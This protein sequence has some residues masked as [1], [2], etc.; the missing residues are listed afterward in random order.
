MTE[1]IILAS[2]NQKKVLELSEILSD[3]E[4]EIVSVSEFE[5][6]GEIEETG[7]T[8][9]EN[10]CLK[11]D[12]TSRITGLP[13]LADD[14][15]LEVEHLS[16]V[17]GIYSAR[18]S[19]PDATD[20][21]NNALLLERLSSASDE[22]RKANF[23]CVIALAVPGKDTVTFEGKCFGEIL[24]EARG[25]G[26]FGYDPLFY[27]VE[28]GC[29]FAEAGSEIKNKISHRARA[30]TKLKKYLEEKGGTLK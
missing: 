19:G 12:T 13:A 6:V 22:E 16:G 2:K 9:V 1:K 11:A 14:S 7:K 28:A 25:D 20:E 5:E 30:L 10:A 3:C 8:F 26:G 29:T 27:S 17:P 4:I 21:E 24:K 15:G 18:F 23:T